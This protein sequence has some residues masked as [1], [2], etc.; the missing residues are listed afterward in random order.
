MAR[1]RRTPIFYGENT[2]K[3]ENLKSLKFS[4]SRYHDKV[5]YDPP[6]LTIRDKTF[7]LVSPEPFVLPEMSPLWSA[8]AYA[9]F[10][11]S[12]PP[13]SQQKSP[14]AQKAEGDLKPVKEVEFKQSEKDPKS[15]S[16][17]SIS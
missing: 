12:P 10:D 16:G 8:V 7:G 11:V 14:A 4:I 13:T 9:A 5:P 1:W 17:C 2:C 6:D 3:L 15:E